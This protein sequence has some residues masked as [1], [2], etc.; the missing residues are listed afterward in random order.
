MKKNKQ[1]LSITTFTETID[2]LTRKGAIEN[3]IAVLKCQGPIFKLLCKFTMNFNAVINDEQL[4]IPEWH[5]AFGIVV[6]SLAATKNVMALEAIDLHLDKCISNLCT[7]RNKFIKMV[8]NTYHN[9]SVELGEYLWLCIIPAL[10]GAKYPVVQEMLNQCVKSHN[11]NIVKLALQVLKANGYNTQG[12]QVSSHFDYKSLLALK[13]YIGHESV[14]KVILKNIESIHPHRIEKITNLYKPVKEL[15]LVKEMADYLESELSLERDAET[16]VQIIIDMFNVRAHVD[17]THR[18][19]YL[20]LIKG[21]KSLISGT[22]IA[23]QKVNISVA[24]ISQES[25]FSRKPSD[26]KQE[27][28]M[29]INLLNS[30]SHNIIKAYSLTALRLCNSTEEFDQLI[31]TNKIPKFFETAW[32]NQL[33]E[34]YE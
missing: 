5:I 9:E 25:L 27:E 19:L 32:L 21:H 12:L 28:S 15:K 22:C 26:L 33:N 13:P 24:G 18:I 14:K 3:M 17:V 1:K 8:E 4:E 2:R 23:L 31:L 6:Q 10:Q 11:F 20:W 30:Q 29:F 16:V 7:F 34:L